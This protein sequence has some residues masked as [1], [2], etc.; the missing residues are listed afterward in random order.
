[1]NKFLLLL[2]FAIISFTSVAQRGFLF[3]SKKDKKVLTLTTGTFVQMRHHY[4]YTIQGILGHIRKD[5]FSVLSYSINKS[6]NDKGFVFFDTIYNG[7]TFYSIH[8]IASI[9]IKKNKSIFK[10][11]QG[12]SYLASMSLT[13]LSL[14]N[15]IKFNDNIGEIGKTIWI[16]L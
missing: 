2:V 5:S 6:I 1:M 9:P 10:T 13:V 4:G 7:Y 8:D 12:A 11:A 3:V 16:A 15:G 14:V